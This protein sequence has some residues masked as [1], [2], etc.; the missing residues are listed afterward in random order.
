MTEVIATREGQRKIFPD[1]VGRYKKMPRPALEAR[2]ARTQNVFD[3]RM[4]KPMHRNEKRRSF[5]IDLGL[6]LELCAI[7]EALGMTS[8]RHSL[9]EPLPVYPPPRPGDT[10]GELAHKTFAQIKSEV[11][12]LMGQHERVGRFFQT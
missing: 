10:R 7:Q 12:H 11:G 4:R 6:E 9:L 8:G 1:M 3:R 5:A 2:L